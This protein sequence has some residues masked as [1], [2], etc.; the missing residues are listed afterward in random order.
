MQLPPANLPAPNQT[1]PAG[2]GCGG[3]ANKDPGPGILAATFT[4]G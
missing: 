4:A 1:N 2:G 3:T